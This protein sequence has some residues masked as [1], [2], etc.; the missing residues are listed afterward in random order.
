MVDKLHGAR[1]RLIVDWVLGA[2]FR[3]T[4]THN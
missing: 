3:T 4:R 2:F 1:H